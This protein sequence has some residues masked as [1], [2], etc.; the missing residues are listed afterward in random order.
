MD[1]LT[2]GWN[3]EAARS[4]VGTFH[5]LPL[6]GDRTIVYKSE[7][8][9]G[10]TFEGF[11]QEAGNVSLRN[12]E[13]K[14]TVK[15]ERAEEYERVGFY[16]VRKD[17]YKGAEVAMIIF[18]HFWKSDSST[19]GSGTPKSHFGV[20]YF[21]ETLEP[22][23]LI[24]FDWIETAPSLGSMVRTFFLTL[25]FRLKNFLGGYRSVINSSNYKTCGKVLYGISRMGHSV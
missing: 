6:H 22:Y 24:R 10:A 18:W 23:A 12:R 2:E 5:D 3:E 13:T 4:V 14:H 16:K 17:G 21:T 8:K 25:P 9:K 19:R 15:G 11:T 20:E 7:T 1:H